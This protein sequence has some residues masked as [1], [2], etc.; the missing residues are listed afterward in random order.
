MLLKVNDLQRLCAQSL[1]NSFKTLA[2]SLL[3]AQLWNSPGA[4]SRG[5]QAA[6]APVASRL[7]IH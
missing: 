1:H 5:V 2:L 4:I 6:P 3:Y 7:E